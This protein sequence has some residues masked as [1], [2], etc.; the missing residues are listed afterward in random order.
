MDAYN[1]PDADGRLTAA[2]PVAGDVIR[3]RRD[4]LEKTRGV[5]EMRKRAHS[6]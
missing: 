3:Q 1:I 6:R 5:A 2:A 4:V